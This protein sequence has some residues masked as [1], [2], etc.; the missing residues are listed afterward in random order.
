MKYTGK[1]DPITCDYDLD[2]EITKHVEQLKEQIEV[3][4]FES[5]GSDFGLILKAL[6]TELKETL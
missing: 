4:R 2:H 1:Y 3:I 5:K 6:I